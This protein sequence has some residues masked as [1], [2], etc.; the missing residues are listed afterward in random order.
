VLVVATSGVQL[1][2]LIIAGVAALSGIGSAVVSG[3]FGKRSENRT[4]RL[5]KEVEDR[6]ETRARQLEE[7]EAQ[8]DSER[9]RLERIRSA[10]DQSVALAEQ[11]LSTLQQFALSMPHKEVGEVIAERKA[12]HPAFVDLVMEIGHLGEDM[13]AIG[14]R[15]PG[16]DLELEGAT[17]KLVESLA[18]GRTALANSSGTPQELLAAWEVAQS[19]LATFR[20]TMRSSLFGGE[21]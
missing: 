21:G 5:A 16:I 11:G 17:T 6:A 1:A 4:A 9:W 8:R 20:R 12:L 13:S 14:A 15:G 7:R 2:T 18:A 3:L 19:G 10:Y